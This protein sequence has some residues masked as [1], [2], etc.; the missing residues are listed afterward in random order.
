MVV[1]VV[2]IFVVILLLFVSWVLPAE[3]TKAGKETLLGQY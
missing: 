3:A 1:V 2:F